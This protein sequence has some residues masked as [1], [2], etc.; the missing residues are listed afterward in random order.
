MKPAARATSKGLRPAL[1]Q[2]PDAPGSVEPGTAADGRPPMTRGIEDESF[3]TSIL[4]WIGVLEQKSNL[5]FVRETGGG[6]S[7]VPIW[8]TLSIL[9]EMDGIAVSELA[10]YAQI[11]R[12]AL[13]HLL[14]GME[15]D[16]LVERRAREGDR[17]TVE[18]H[19]LDAGRSTFRRM[20]PIR[21]AVMRRAAEGVPQ[22]DLEDLLLTLR[23]LSA[24]LEAPGEG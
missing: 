21:R 19:I 3:L 5:A 13:S 2:P 12:T 20:L 23:K 16:G 7:D 1:R 4:Y 18:V 15:R 14:T 10:R 6:K 22:E 17:R 9:N 8:R 11:E 24:N